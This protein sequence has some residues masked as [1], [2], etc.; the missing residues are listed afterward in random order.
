MSKFLKL[1]RVKNK[2]T[3]L[4]DDRPKVSF[5][6]QAL[7]NQLAITMMEKVEGR[8]GLRLLMVIT[9][10]S[11][12]ALRLAKENGVDT[13][14]PC[15]I[16]YN[17]YAYQTNMNDCLSIQTEIIH[18]TMDNL[19]SRGMLPEYLESKMDQFDITKIAIDPY[20]DSVVDGLDVEKKQAVLN[21]Q[22]IVEKAKGKFLK[23]QVELPAHPSN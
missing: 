8:A 6:N 17:A 18:Q 11:V 21:L 14:K 10:C 20:D 5:A 9:E 3:V 23:Q 19:Q 15:R 2:T 22:S 7:A 16:E 4:E 1:K 12:K 13:T